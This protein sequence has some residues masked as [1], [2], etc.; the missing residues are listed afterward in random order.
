MSEHESRVISDC[1]EGL[2]IPGT[3]CFLNE[4][5][6]PRFF[7][8]M[9][10]IQVDRCFSCGCA[11]RSD[12]HI[13]DGFVMH[14]G[15]INA[16]SFRVSLLWQR[17]LFIRP[18]ASSTPLWNTRPRFRG[19]NFLPP[20]FLYSRRRAAVDQDTSPSILHICF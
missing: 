13:Q 20:V 4:S 3:R 14:T 7:P 15:K 17:P 10:S 1:L 5:I 16:A 12:S 6:Q 19:Y 8:A 2:N 11:G 18:A 9:E